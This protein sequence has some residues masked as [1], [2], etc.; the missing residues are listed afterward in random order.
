MELKKEKGTGKIAC[1][2]LVAL[3]IFNP[4]GKS[5]DKTFKKS[6]LT[7]ILTLSFLA[8]FSLFAMP[9]VQASPQRRERVK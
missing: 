2:A 3:L 6:F 1:I 9:I 8:A 4:F 7:V 5:G